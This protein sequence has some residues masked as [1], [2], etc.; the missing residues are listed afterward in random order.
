MTEEQSNIGIETAQVSVVAKAPK[1]KTG[2][3]RKDI[4]FTVHVMENG[5]TVS[6]RE[7]VIKGVP[8]PAV[9]VPT[10]TEFF[11]PI[12]PT[13]PNLAFLKDHFL[14]E[15]RVTEEQALLIVREAT[16]ILKTEPTLLDVAAP[17]TVCGDIHGQYFDLVKL[18]EVGGDP[19]T[20]RYLFLGDYVDRGYY[21]IECVLYLWS[22]KIWYPDSVF[23]MRG[24]H[25]CKHLTDYFTFKL[26]CDHKYSEELY[27][28]CMESFCALP[29]GALMNKQFLCI[30]GGLSPE[31]TTLDDF[32][33]IDRFREPPTYGVM[34]DL[35]W[36]DPIENF[37]QERN[38][39]FYTHNSAR[40]CSYY[41]SY[42]AACTF[43]EKNGL[44]S[45]IRA[46]E[47]QDA[48]FKMYATTKTTGFPALIT[49]FSAPNYLDIYNNKA[50]ILKY[51]NNVLNIRQFNIT[52][53]LIAILNIC[54]KEELDD[55]KIMVM[56][57]VS[58]QEVRKHVIKN[59]ILAVGRMARVF[60]VLREEKEKIS[61][62]KGLMGTTSLPAGTLALGAEGIKIAIRTFE[63][64]K[65]ADKDNEK[66]PPLNGEKM[67]EPAKPIFGSPVTL[68]FELQDVD[69]NESPPLP[70]TG[71]IKR[72][73]TLTK[74]EY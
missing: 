34:C 12:D 42:N 66:L 16:R 60:N 17:V 14:H 65:Q 48:G 5:E 62:L 18:F 52:D 19:A 37:G 74:T 47:A 46:H 44:L 69:R 40:G 36:A 28:A 8:A 20:T 2:R 72:T 45:I 6:T 73:P 30:H 32:D 31:L 24:N 49:I 68:P 55:E 21:S 51:E 9:N 58:E 61:E 27:D 13:K 39:E 7:R 23:L 70:N 43:L 10:A 15:G 22:L 41:Y 63:Q 56:D 57:E 26:E 1:K 54:S 67:P 4:D 11:S 33:K 25:E 29:L 71:R 50:A 3:L 38:N 64:A 59:K 35:L 53:M